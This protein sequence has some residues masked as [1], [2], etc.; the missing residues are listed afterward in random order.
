MARSQN[1]PGVELTAVGVEGYRAFAKSEEIELRPLTL[2]YGFNSVG[3]SA[4][5]RAL[6][7]IAASSTGLSSIPIDLEAP[8][9]RGASFAN[10]LA[11]HQESPTLSF[12]LAWTPEKRDRNQCTLWERTSILS[13]IRAKAS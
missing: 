4:L 3:K 9:A 6:P 2:L 12:E 10:L 7:L 11:R 5:L 8:I 13:S 1:V